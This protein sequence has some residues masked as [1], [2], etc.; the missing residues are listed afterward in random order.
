MPTF[1][2]GQYCPLAYALDILGERWT[3]LIIR[4]L[5]HGPRTYQLLLQNL[6]DMGAIKLTR[7]L[8]YLEKQGI[9]ER[10]LSEPR[11]ADE[12]YFLTPRGKSLEDIIRGLASWGMEKMTLP[13]RYEVYSPLWS[14]LEFQARFKPSLAK[15]LNMMF[16]LDIDNETHHIEIADGKMTTRSGPAATPLF[17]IST[18]SATFILVLR[19]ILSIQEAIQLERI[20]VEG[21]IAALSRSL[22][23]L[24]LRSKEKEIAPKPAKKKEDPFPNI[25]LYG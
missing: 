1:S 25:E 3:L 22:D 12:P 13:T 14:L 8:N 20:Y 4:E 11:S 19:G 9:V 18:D 17:T 6:P 5:I 23:I 21:S 2:Y 10:A 7:R 16:E 15:G 24:G